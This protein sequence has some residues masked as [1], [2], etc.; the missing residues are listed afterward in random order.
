MAGLKGT[1]FRRL[2][3]TVGVEPRARSL[4]LTA[5]LA[6]AEERLTLA[7]RRRADA[8]ARHLRW[9]RKYALLKA[10]DLRLAK[11]L[12]RMN[13]AAGRTRELELEVVRLTAALRASE[14]ETLKGFK[15]IEALVAA[16]E[17][18]ARTGR[19]QVNTIEVKLDL[20]DGA[21]NTLDRRY[22][23][24]VTRSTGGGA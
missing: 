3:R 21:L 5:R 14:R 22:R 10:R 18:L 4:E 23:T 16:A 7:R 17:E 6:R 2:L 15:K 13:E 1:L 8:T 11:E 19:A 9:K 20:V 24:I 12:Q